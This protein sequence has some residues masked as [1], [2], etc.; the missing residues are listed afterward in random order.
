[1]S[2]SGSSSI[3]R[4]D[5]AKN[6][7]FVAYSDQGARP[8]GV[9][10]IVHKGF[11]YVGHMFS[12]GFSVLDVRDPRRPEAVAFVP[13][14]K[15]TRSHHLQVADKL[16][17]AINGPSIWTLA[18]FQDQ[19]KYFA[20]T[21]TTSFKDNELAFAAGV[22]IY[23]ISVPS[24]PREIAFLEIP[25]LGVN[26]IW[27]TGGRYAYVAVHE[28]GYT[29][30]VMAV[31]DLSVP[32]RPEIVSRWWL[33]GQW[34]AGGE[35]SALPAGKRHA[36]H[37]AII[38]GDFAY[39]AWRDGGITIHSIRDLSKPVMI[40]HS[41]W[42]PPF[43][44]GTHTAL[45]L[46]ERNLLVVADE[47][48]TVNCANGIPRIWVV[49]IRRPESPVPIST[50]PVPKEFDYCQ[51]GGKFGPHNLHENRPGSFQSSDIVFATYLNAGVRA[52]DLRDPF[53][54]VELAHYVP[55]PPARMIDSRP[56]APAVVQSGD[57]FVDPEGLI[58]LTDPNA[59][60]HI[61]Q[62][63]G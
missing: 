39:G 63:E 28:Q 32:E 47:A 11:A 4:A 29:D 45:P 46:P 58:Y 26:R 56:N 23:D 60:L 21:L 43:T 52:Y 30:H 38:A 8:D 49:D 33:P 14:P 6:I 25:G 36:A 18:Q 17:L 22:R 3:A 50:L 2:A 10:V 12:D 55:P 31:I 24:T 15:N 62:F 19:S 34:I 7:S 5:S 16:L 20:S 13:M 35:L 51:K 44:G 37:H 1:M 27:W 41:N 54:P 40:S 61:L 53:Q 9:Q 48:T 57:I 59:G 42:S